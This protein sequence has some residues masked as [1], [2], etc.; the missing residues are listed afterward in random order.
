MQSSGRVEQLKTNYTY[1]SCRFRELGFD[2]S[3]T[4]SAI[5]PLFVGDEAT[6]SL[7]ARDFYDAGIFVNAVFHPAVPPRK[8]RFRLSIMATHT[9]EEL[10]T[11]IE[12]AGKLGKKYKII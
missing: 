9:M 1:M 4:E 2:I 5:I 11:F 3:H 12:V 10:D 8:S 7:M 6:I